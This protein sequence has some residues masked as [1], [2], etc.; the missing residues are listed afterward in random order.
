MSACDHCKY[1]N[2]YDCD[3]EYNRHKNCDEFYLD[4]GTLK[5]KQQKAIRNILDREDED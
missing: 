2:S 5:K 3:D 4:F 1:R